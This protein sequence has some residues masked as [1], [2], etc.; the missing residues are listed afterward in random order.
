MSTKPR[1]KTR[2]TELDKLV[3]TW[4]KTT[5]DRRSQSSI[6]VVTFHF[7]RLDGGQVG[8]SV[9]RRTQTCLYQLREIGIIIV[10]IDHE[11]PANINRNIL[12]H[13]NTA[14]PNPMLFFEFWGTKDREKRRILILSRAPPTIGIPMHTKILSHADGHADEGPC[15]C[16]ST[17]TDLA[18][19]YEKESLASDW[20]WRGKTGLKELG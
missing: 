5:R 9:M 3:E 11:R 6:E 8:I 12:V 20:T 13:E 15:E 16:Y 4:D 14:K 7:F 17:N 18:I 1:K 2:H 19:P 10:F